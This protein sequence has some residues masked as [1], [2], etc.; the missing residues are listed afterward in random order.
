MFAEVKKFNDSN[1]RSYWRGTKVVCSL[2]GSTHMP[3]QCRTEAKVQYQEWIWH[4]PFLNTT[5]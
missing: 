3:H 5:A 2:T 1:I 4:A